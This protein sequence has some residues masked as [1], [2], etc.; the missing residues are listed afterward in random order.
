M[1]G[2]D[3]RHTNRWLT[4]NPTLFDDH[5]TADPDPSLPDVQKTWRCK[6]CDEVFFT[7][8]ERDYVS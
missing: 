7:V 5:I 4:H 1:S 2:S 3:R 6:K 8:E